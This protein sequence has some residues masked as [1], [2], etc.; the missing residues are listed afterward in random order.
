ME[1]QLT[2]FDFLNQ[3]NDDFETMSIQRAV[4]IL[5]SNTPLK[6]KLNER[7]F[8]NYYTAKHKGII[9]EVG[10]DHFAPGVFNGRRF[11]SCSANYG[12]AGRSNPTLSIEE[13]IR[14]LNGAIKDYLED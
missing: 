14:F 8:S 4:E 7:F 1:G 2:I 10:F 3:V 5:Q 13:A 11:L 12:H 9:F 6:F